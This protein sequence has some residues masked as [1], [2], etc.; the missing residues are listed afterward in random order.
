VLKRLLAQY[1]DQLAGSFIVATETTIRI[2][3]SK[4]S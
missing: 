4:D 1:A 3:R 2:A